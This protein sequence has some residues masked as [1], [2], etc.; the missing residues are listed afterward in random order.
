M[1]DWNDLRFFL[2]VAQT[3]STLAAS[4]EL[5][6]N[7]TTVA[8][9]LA[10]LEEALGERL[11]DRGSSGYRLTETGRTALPAAERVAAEAHRFRTTVAERGRR[12]AG[13]VRVTTNEAIAN[14]LVT[15]CLADFAE[16][17]PDIRVEVVVS[18]QKLDLAAGEAD[19]ALRAGPFPTD[20]ALIARKLAD[21]PWAIYCSRGYAERRGAPRTPAELAAH[22][23]LLGDGGLRNAPA[24]NWLRE[25]APGA[26]VASRSNSLTNHVVA[27]RSGLGV[28]PLPRMEGDAA[29]DLVLCMDAPQTE[30]HML[31][32]LLRPELK[33]VPRVRAL[34]D[35]VTARA[36]ALR[37]MLEGRRAEPPVPA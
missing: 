18:D 14:A 5:G 34:V 21:V 8:R 4:R 23:L 35:F 3:G 24:M 31:S 6:V 9:R 27:V 36:A 13:A 32:L 2:A 29:P 30:P 26:Y 33:D 12:L 16:I 20:P 10:A 25:Q 11:F 1:Y 7:Q 28:G 19:V 15:P 37:P 17:Y 22:P